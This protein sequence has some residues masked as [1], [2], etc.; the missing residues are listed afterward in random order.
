MQMV[1][2][3]QQSSTCFSRALTRQKSKSRMSSSK[4]SHFPDH[5][6]ARYRNVTQVKLLPALPPTWPTGSL[7]GG[8]LRDGLG[9]DMSWS[10][11]LL[12]EVTIKSDRAVETRTVA[13]QSAS[14]GDMHAA[15]GSRISQE[16]DTIS[17]S[18]TPGESITLT[19]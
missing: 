4:S 10:G 8:R 18:L 13:L 17:F 9:I 5:L 1:V 6:L 3:Q 2:R 11:S 19:G 14:F 15:N 16:G 12:R 7:S